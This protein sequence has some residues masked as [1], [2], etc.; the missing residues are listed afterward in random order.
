MMVLM[1][2]TMKKAKKILNHWNNINSINPLSFFSQSPLFQLGSCMATSVYTTTLPQQC[3]QSPFSTHILPF[4]PQS[5]SRPPFVSRPSRCPHQLPFRFIPPPRPKTDTTH[6]KI[7][8]LFSFYLYCVN[9]SV[10]FDASDH[11]TIAFSL[12]THQHL[13]QC[14]RG[15]GAKIIRCI[16]NTNK[17]S[18]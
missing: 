12:P 4:P 11:H 14:K 7:C 15:K 5:L 18:F 3:I 17:Q 8:S 13:H 9:E 2:V 1:V 10:N 16:I 6:C